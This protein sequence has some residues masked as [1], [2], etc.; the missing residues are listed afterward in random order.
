MDMRL[1]TRVHGLDDTVS[2]FVSSQGVQI[3][4]F[5]II[6]LSMTG[7]L[8]RIDATDKKLELFDTLILNFSNGGF[9]QG[10][11]IRKSD[12]YIA[13]KITQA[14]EWYSNYIACR[15]NALYKF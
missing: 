10:Y 4:D 12:S 9:V 2:V 6:D 11:V 3:P 1:S 8:L 15:V 7:I 13:L 5:D 14:N